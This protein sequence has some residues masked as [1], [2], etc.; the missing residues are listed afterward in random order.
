[1][2]DS[3][4]EE[5]VPLRQSDVG[6][7]ISISRLRWKILHTGRKPFKCPE[8]HCSKTYRFKH[9]VSKHQKQVHQGEKLFKCPEEGCLKA[10]NYKCHLNKHKLIHTKE[11]PLMRDLSGENLLK[12]EMFNEVDMPL[13]E[14]VKDEVCEK[15][16]VKKEEKIQEFKEEKLQESREEKLQE[17]VKRE[18][19]ESAG[20]C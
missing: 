3:S 8:P 15:K 12:Q 4:L 17:L 9:S 2:T 18:K 5:T 11:Q 1:M 13:Q 10:F 16:F 14:M 6:G 19:L 7:S 20:S